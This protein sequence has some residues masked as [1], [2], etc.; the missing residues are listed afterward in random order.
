MKIKSVQ[1]REI[2]DSRGNPTIEVDVKLEDGAYGRASVPSGA[3]TGTHEAVELRDN[4]R[5]RFFGKG[6]LNAVNNVNTIINN[7]LL[8]VNANQQNKI[9][10]ILIKAD[11]TENKNH[12]GANAILGT[13]IASA[14]AASSSYNMP[15]YKY[16]N[17]GSSK[18]FLLPTPLANILNG[19]MHASNSADFQEY[20][21]VPIG[22]QSFKESIQWIS[23][24]YHS[25][26][27]IL[28][29]KN[30]STT[31]GDEGGF[32][33]EFK[34]NEEPLKF[35]TM[36][37]EKS[38]F[39]PGIDI[40]IALDPATSE[41]F[42]DN[43]YNLQ[44]ES[45]K[46]SS[47]DLIE[48]WKIWASK[49]PIISIEDAMDE[50][51]WNGWQGLTKA[52]GDKMQLVGDD[53]IVTNRKRLQKAIDLN[54]ANSVLIKLNQIGTISETLETIELA[55]KSGWSTIISHRS[56]ETEDTT[57]AHLAVASGAGQI[58]T[59]APARSDRT[60]KYNELLRIEEELENKGKFAGNT[61]FSQYIV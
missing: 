32:A 10:E 19:G 45:R 11:G 3:S 29:S 22:A 48:L 20:M 2:L 30:M 47:L 27:K 16:L 6:V 17:D 39:K 46:L 60:A 52:I 23:E 36:A 18:N 5:S 61:R 58:K 26:K 31:V 59:G 38:N 14:K 21:I 49:Y 33:P 8:G 41:I 42:K 24:I 57:I 35:I 25:L 15:L 4:D 9:D 56:G 51:D 37:I 53:L 28:A 12:L 40:A 34:N 1:A 54:A 43:K 50:D 13:S 44:T 7:S 55:K